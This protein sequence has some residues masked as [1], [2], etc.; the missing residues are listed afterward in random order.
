MYIFKP[1]IRFN[2]L[3]I[4]G[5]FLFT[6][7]W[8]FPHGAEARRAKGKT[9]SSVNR[10]GHKNANVNRNRNK[11]VNVNVNR[12]HNNHHHH[13]VGAAVAVG[14]AT[15][16]VVGSIVAASTMP[17]SCVTTIINGITYRQCGNT[18]YQPQQSGTQVNYIVV[19]PPH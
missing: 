14:I 10:G 12:G 2:A 3:L 1:S 6:T 7:C 18:W 8:I 13:N 5:F 19:N 4:A 11:N 15:G 17:P 16:I 9:H